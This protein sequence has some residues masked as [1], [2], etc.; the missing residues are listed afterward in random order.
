MWTWGE[1]FT[2]FLL[3]CNC[4]SHLLVYPFSRGPKSVLWRRIQGHCLLLVG[5]IAVLILWFLLHWGHILWPTPETRSPRLPFWSE[6]PILFIGAFAPSAHLFLLSIHT[7]TS[8]LRLLFTL[9][10]FCNT[11]LRLVFLL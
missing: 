6:C 9:I 4:P 7:A 8:R 10:G 3:S 2:V 1:A 5:P 11:P